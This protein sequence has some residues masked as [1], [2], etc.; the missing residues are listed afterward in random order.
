MLLGL[1]KAQI[2]YQSAVDMALI[3]FKWKSCLFYIDDVIKYPNTVEEH[4]YCVEE[5]L[6]TIPR[7]EAL[8]RWTSAPSSTTRW[9]ISDKLSILE[10]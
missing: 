3:N 4:I 10:N 7:Q 8:P 1:T 6:T 5:I 2:T 9:D